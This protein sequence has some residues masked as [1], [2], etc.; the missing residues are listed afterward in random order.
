MLEFFISLEGKGFYILILF[1]LNMPSLAFLFFM[2]RS[3][4][5]MI[6]DIKDTYVSEKTFKET[7]DQEHRLIIT[8]IN[9]R[10]DRL[11][12]GVNKKI[13]GLNNTF[14]DLQKEILQIARDKK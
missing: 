14:Q 1:G 3:Y 2:D 11:E 7:R 12:K 8:P 10:L 9:N 5:K 6:D 13:D 4:R